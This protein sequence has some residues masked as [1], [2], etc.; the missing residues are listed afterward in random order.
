MSSCAQ[1]KSSIRDPPTLQ[2]QLPEKLEVLGCVQ[3][4]THSLSSFPLSLPLSSHF[5]FSWQKFTTFYFSTKLSGP[6]RDFKSSRTTTAFPIAT[7][8]PDSDHRHLQRAPQ[9]RQGRDCQHRRDGILSLSSAAADDTSDAV[10]SYPPVPPPTALVF[11]LD[12]GP[13]CARGT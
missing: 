5:L 2:A 3:R 10:A 1:R 7:L 9:A 12:R 6:L 11:A 13:P 8:S 4:D